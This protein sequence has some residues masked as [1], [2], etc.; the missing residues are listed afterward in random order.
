MKQKELSKADKLT[1]KLH[2]ELQSLNAHM[3]TNMV[4]KTDF[5]S[6]KRAVNEK[7]HVIEISTEK[8]KTL[9]I[10]ANGWH[11]NYYSLAVLCTL[12]VVGNEGMCVYFSRFYFAASA[13]L[14]VFVCW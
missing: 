6:Y 9:R 10:V 12:C 4:A 1:R 5:E 3:T 13:V 7:V 8:N 14:S 2:D 11:N